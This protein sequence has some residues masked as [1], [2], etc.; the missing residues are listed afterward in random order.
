MFCVCGFF[1]FSL[2]TFSTLHSVETHI[3]RLHPDLKLCACGGC[4]RTFRQPVSLKWHRSL[5]STEKSFPCQYCGKTFGDKWNLKR[6]TFFHTGGFLMVES[7]L[8]NTYINSIADSC[9]SVLFFLLLVQERGLTYVKCA[10]R[11]FVTS[12][13]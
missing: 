5:H 11:H 6:N 13:T 12:H 1:F 2:Q 10:A 4:E 3:G 8:S 7:Q 9:F